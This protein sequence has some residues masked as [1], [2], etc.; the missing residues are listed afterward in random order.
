MGFLNDHADLVWFI[1]ETSHLGSTE[2]NPHIRG[3]FES[4]SFSMPST[5][6]GAVVDYKNQ[7]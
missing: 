5:L 4:V 7:I 3:F 1:T 6:W 2:S